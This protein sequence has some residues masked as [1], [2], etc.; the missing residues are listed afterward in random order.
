MMNQWVQL[1]MTLGL[2]GLVVGSMVTLQRIETVNFSRADEGMKR[3]NVSEM[4]KVT[5]AVTMRPMEVALA[6][7]VFDE[8]VSS[9]TPTPTARPTPTAT[10][11]PLPTSTPPLAVV[12]DPVKKEVNIDGMAAEMIEAHN[13][14]RSSVGVAGLRWS[15]GLANDAK[16]WAELLKA[17]GCQG[18]HDTGNP[19]GENIYWKWQTG[20]SGQSGLI[21]N[22]SEVVQSWLNERSQY[23]YGGNSC[24]GVCGHYTQVVWKNTTEVG[25]GVSS[26]WD[27]DKQTDV[28][29]CRYR[30]A[31]NWV[32]Q[33]PY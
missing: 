7:S 11:T 14:A 22:A 19:D 28:W 32:G 18:R 6:R 21:S 27:G 2:L 15:D 5:P 3:M 29:V 4:V 33:K 26:C 24:S 31:G 12:N 13:V 30:P 8:A 17:E 9:P 25:C 16:S 1:G 23:D 20:R 10:A